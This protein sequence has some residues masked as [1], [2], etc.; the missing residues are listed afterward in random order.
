MTTAQV[1][2]FT[3]LEIQALT[4]DQVLALTTAQVGALTTAQAAALPVVPFSIPILSTAQIA[5]LTIAQIESLTTDQIVSLS[6][7]QAKALSSTAVAA[8]STD[9]IVAL[10]TQDFA[11]MT[12]TQL[13]ALSSAQAAVLSTTQV[14]A[15]S[16][17]QIQGF[18]TAAYQA[19]ATGTPIILDLDGNGVN[20]LSISA[21]VKFDLFDEGK[22]VNTGWVSSGD[23][24]LVLDRN[25]D[26]QINDGSELFGS[27]TKLAN[28]QKATDGYTALR[29]L[30]SNHDGVIS[31]S[32]A[33]YADLRVWVDANSDGVTETGELKTLASLNIAN[34]SLN[35]AVGSDKDN[36]NILGLTSTYETTDGATHAAADVWFLAD[37]N[38]VDS[39]AAAVDSAIVALSQ[40]AAVAVVTPVVAAA[41]V[42]A[43]ALVTADAVPFGAVAGLV[44][45]QNVATPLA[46]KDDLCTRVS[47]L[48]QAIGSF[49]ESGVNET[50]AVP[51]LDATGGAV[52]SNTTATAL[53]V[54]S[55]VDV[56]KQ[57]DANGNLL[58]KPGT[59]VAS[60]ST[61]LNLPGVQDPASAG[62]LAVKG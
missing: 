41:P 20:T 47:G 6:T 49:A 23:G 44:P 50:L 37:K 38:K 18:T 11:A 9:Q 55:M 56:M 10:E 24:L 40:P 31:N 14:E 15:L 39:S 54:G 27:S 3:T 21:G 34:I 35:A 42:T 13:G 1:R 45:D 29:E 16:S 22:K 8:L 36:G 30:D 51:R 61:T 19:L 59:A 33:V 43:A 5:T 7:A 28:G 62:F 4:T 52:A 46:P 60:G 26:G 58:A 32:D 12:T 17:S 57:F 25:H 48:A 53:T 2:A